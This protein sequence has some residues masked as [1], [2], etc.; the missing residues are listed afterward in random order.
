[1][2]LRA[3]HRSILD[4]CHLNPTNQLIET[5]RRHLVSSVSVPTAIRSTTAAPRQT[6]VNL[7]PLQHLQQL[8][9]TLQLQKQAPL[10]TPQHL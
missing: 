9:Q 8:Q 10:V 1:M 6:V 4:P 7:H 5:T 2:P 3:V